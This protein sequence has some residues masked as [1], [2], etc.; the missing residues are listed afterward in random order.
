LNKEVMLP[1]MRQAVRLAVWAGLMSLGAW[2]SLPFGPVPFTL[3]SFFVIL[4]GFV[5][6][7]VAA[8]VA[9]AIY[10][11]AGLTGLPVFAGGAAGPALIFGPTVGYA[12]SFPPAAALAG[13]SRYGSW[14]PDWLKMTV[15]GLAASVLILASGSLGLVLAMG[16]TPSVA[17]AANVVFVPGGALKTVAAVGLAVGRNKRLSRRRDGRD[18]DASAPTKRS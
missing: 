10:L 9:A 2:I 16:L 5:E 6:G 14:G 18:A 17:V 4:A 8:A 15:C 13:L 7:P 3:Q 11:A 12:L 1:E